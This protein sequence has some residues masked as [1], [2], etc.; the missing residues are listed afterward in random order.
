VEERRNGTLFTLSVAQSLVETG[1][2]RGDLKR[3]DSSGRTAYCLVGALDEAAEGL[4]LGA[5]ASRGAAQTVLCVLGKHC[6]GF[7]PRW[8]LSFWNDR[9]HKLEVLAVLAGARRLCEREVR[10][11]CAPRPSRRREPE[12]P[13]AARSKERHVKALAGQA[14]V[15]RCGSGAGPVHRRNGL[16]RRRSSPAANARAAALL[17]LTSHR[18]RQASLSC[19]EPT[20]LSPP[21]SKTSCSWQM[22]QGGGDSRLQSCS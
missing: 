20:K 8:R 5:R 3:T 12:R 7:L 16:G 11:G 21:C 19:A 18:Q 22:A 6:P 9:R 4:E 2:M 13:R 15:W 10:L 17:P 14:T 1:W